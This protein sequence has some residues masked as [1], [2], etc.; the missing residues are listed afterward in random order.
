M[1]EQTYDFLGRSFADV[2]VSLLGPP[3]GDFQRLGAEKLCF[4]R[5]LRNSIN[6]KCS[7][8]D[9]DGFECLQKSVKITKN[10]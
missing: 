9:F 2:S 6:Y 5:D 1:S 3:N 10:Q 7:V 8:T 4:S